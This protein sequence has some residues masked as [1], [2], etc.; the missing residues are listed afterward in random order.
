MELKLFEVRDFPK[1]QVA[2]NRTTME[3][4]PDIGLG[5]GPPRASFNRTTMELKLDDG[6]DYL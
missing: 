3:L 1:A 6:I 2:F 4:K 5:L